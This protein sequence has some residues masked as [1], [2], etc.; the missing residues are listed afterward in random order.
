M[1]GTDNSVTPLL[2][3]R[4]RMD[5]LSCQQSVGWGMV[6]SSSATEAAASAGG[7]GSSSISHPSCD[8]Q[9]NDNV[10]VGNVAARIIMA[11]LVCLSTLLQ[12]H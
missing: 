10:V 12:G 7:G 9:M 6:S 8:A 5:T 11:D 4:R 1:T 2:T 3:D